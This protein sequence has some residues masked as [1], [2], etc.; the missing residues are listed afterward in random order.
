M[1]NNLI[2]EDE[3]VA[4][5]RQNEKSASTTEKYLRDIR[6]YGEWLQDN[7]IKRAFINGVKAKT[8]A[9]DYKD[10]LK[11]EGLTPATINTK[12]AAINAYFRFMNFNE[13]IR[14]L[15]IQRKI[16]MNE[17]RELSID[18]YK[19]LVE[20]ARDMGKERIALAMETMAATGM[21]VSE[22]QY[23]T[24]ENLRCNT[25]QVDLK[26]KIRTIFVPQRLALKL[27]VFAANS[28]ITEG[29]VFRT[30]SGE[31]VKRKQIWTEMKEIG[32]KAGI[33]DSKVFPHNLRHVFAK[34]YYK[35]CK[36]IA[37]L[38]DVLGHSNL[39]TTRVY[40]MDSGLECQRQINNLGLVC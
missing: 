9:L 29:Y 31:L 4:Y 13:R 40:L 3:F 30:S 39:E 6:F 5:L 21:R 2:R 26:N 37:R 24:V 38:A 16:F 23:V 15:K 7:D 27:M 20:T 36:D 18:E 12:L 11:D 35:Q 22:L 25:I 33:P 34:T 14:Y 19:T 17:E 32:V 8:I 1:K 10:Y 28:G